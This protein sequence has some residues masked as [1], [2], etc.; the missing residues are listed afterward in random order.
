MTKLLDAPTIRIPAMLYLFHRLEQRLDGNPALIVVDEGWKVLDDPVFVRRI[1]DWEKTIR[2]RNGVVG[3]CTQ[4]ASDALDSR[5]ASA[6]IEQAATQVFFPNNRAK[7]SDYIDGFGLTE[8]EFELVRSLPD[9]SRCF[10][11]K[12]GDHSVVARL[13]LTG[14]GGELAVLAGTERAVRRLMRCASRSATSPRPGCRP[15]WKAGARHE[16]GMRQHGRRRGDPRDPLDRR[17]PDPDLRPGRLPGPDAGAR[18]ASSRRALT[19]LLTIYVAFIGYRMLF[20]Q[21]DTR[22]ADAPAIGLKIGVILALVTSWSTFQTIVFNVADRGAG[23][24]RQPGVRAADRRW[25]LRLGRKPDRRPP[26]GLRRTQRHAVAFGKQTGGGANVKSY[27]SPQAAAAEA[28]STAT[29]AIFIAGPGVIAAATLADRH[30][31]RGRAG[32]HRAGAVPG[33]ARAV[34]RLGA[35]AGRGG[36]HAA[37]GLAA[38]GADAV[39]AGA[40]DRR[41]GSRSARPCSSTRR[42]P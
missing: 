6:I 14:L 13:D 19:A 18:A 12:R 31:D 11:I 34:R 21:G 23:R 8:H 32:V 40:L 16:P 22:L 35:R 41:A 37:G 7:A 39:G 24:D 17:V 5:I 15:S 1:K 2:K 28:V 3:F 30:P 9:T 27:S 25:P 36:L 10:L 4:S 20:A 42:P 26:D 38:G 29:G 33:D